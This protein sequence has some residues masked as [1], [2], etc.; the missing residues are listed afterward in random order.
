MTIKIN[1]KG[2]G[3][4]RPFEFKCPSCGHE[5]E[6]EQRPSDPMDNHDCPACMES[7]LIRHHTGAPSMDADWHDSQKSHNL[8]WDG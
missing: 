7:K 2:S 6:V 5:C 8:N 4:P 3:F 1:Y